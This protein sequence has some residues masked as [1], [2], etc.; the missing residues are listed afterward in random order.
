[1][2][3]RI[4]RLEWRVALA[5]RRRLALSAAVPVLLLLP[6][7]ASGAA[8]AHRA[9]VYALFVVFFG[10]FGSAAPMVRDGRRGWVERLLLTGYGARPWL[11]E[12]TAA[13]AAL[14][15]LELAPALAG[16]M[17]LEGASP[18]GGAAA[19]GAVLLALLAANLLGVLTGAA[20]RS[21]GEAALACATVGLVALHLAGAFRPPAAGTW[22]EAAAAVSPFLPAVEA[23]RALAV[24]G[25]GGGAAVSV[26]S[27]SAAGWGL[28]AAATAL[29]LAGAWAGAP[30][31]AERLTGDTTEL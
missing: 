18:V 11:L 31:V 8:P 21:L 23:T 30:R 25:A 19:V 3:G 4:W 2:S 10:L 29:L 7:A 17:W 27:L 12:R 28:P 1:M 6:V 20:V 14:D 16:V 13:H 24:G 26:G 9:T 5:R 15:A 22:Q